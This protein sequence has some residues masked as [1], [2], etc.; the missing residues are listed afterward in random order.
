[1]EISGFGVTTVL[2]DANVKE[3]VTTAEI[4]IKMMTLV[5]ML[6]SLGFNISQSLSAYR[7]RFAK[8]I[9]LVTCATANGSSPVQF[10]AWLY[11]FFCTCRK[12]QCADRGEHDDVDNFFH[13]FMGFKFL[14]MFSTL[15][16]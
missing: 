16:L 13:G 9:S 8:A 1:L 12:A 7:Y 15:K 14:N 4:A 6:I 5:F 11:F 10:S 3:S 2:F